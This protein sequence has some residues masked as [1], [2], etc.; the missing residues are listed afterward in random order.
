MQVQAQ[1]ETV[2]TEK[3]IHSCLKRSFQHMLDCNPFGRLFQQGTFDRL[4][5][6]DY[7]INFLFFKSIIKDFI[8]HHQ[9][10]IFA[11]PY[12]ITAQDEDV[13]ESEKK[14][15][16]STNASDKTNPVEISLDDILG[17]TEQEKAEREAFES[18]QTPNEKQSSRFP[19]LDSS[20]DSQITSTSPQRK[21]KLRGSSD[22]STNTEDSSSL[23]TSLRD[24]EKSPH[25]KLV[26]SSNDSLHSLYRNTSG[27]RISPTIPHNNNNKKKTRLAR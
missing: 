9:K 22:T 11:L 4:Q 10:Y 18:S 27:K 16:R 14:R 13:D 21:K 8:L 23:S 2:P 7:N 25:K 12:T 26:S 3:T 19:S 17:E 24:Q 5:Q 20:V 1:R 6:R 15:K